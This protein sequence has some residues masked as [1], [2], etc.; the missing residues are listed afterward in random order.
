MTRHAGILK[1]RPDPFLYEHIAV[2]DATGFHL[3]ANLSAPGFRLRALDDFE[4]PSWLTHLHC[5]HLNSFLYGLRAGGHE[6]I[7]KISCSTETKPA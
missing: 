3:D 6:M 1:S 7:A 2:A 4:I 5:F